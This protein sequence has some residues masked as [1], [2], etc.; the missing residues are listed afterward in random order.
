MSTYGL[1][2]GVARDVHGE[3][4]WLCSERH[5]FELQI[6]KEDRNSPADGQLE[7]TCSIAGLPQ[8]I[9]AHLASTC[10]INGCLL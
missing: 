4:L 1:L 3:K 2:R 9:G 5:A 6:E 8:F 7:A 10:H